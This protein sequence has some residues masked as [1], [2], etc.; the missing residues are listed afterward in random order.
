VEELAA[1]TFSFVPNL[2][3]LDLRHNRLR[4]VSGNQIPVDARRTRV[5][6]DAAGALD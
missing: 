3:R 5:A 2:R 4:H 6:G 1:D